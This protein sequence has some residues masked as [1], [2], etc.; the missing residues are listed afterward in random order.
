MKTVITAF[1]FII[2]VTLASPVPCVS[3]A[4]ATY[5]ALSGGCSVG[6]A[7]F[8]NFSALSFVNSAGVPA[9]T[10]DEIEVIP[11][12]TPTDA[13]LTFVYLSATGA[14]TPVTLSSSGQLFSF[15][16]NFDITVSPSSLS[17]IQMAS[18]FSNT[19]PGSV[20]TTKTA[21]LIG[22]PTFAP[23]TVS[24]GGVSNAMGTYNGAII[25]VSG[26]GTF[27]ITDTTSLQAQSGSVTQAGFENFFDLTPASNAAT[28][29]LGTLVLLGAGLIFLSLTGRATRKRR[30]KPVPPPSGIQIARLIPN[31]QVVS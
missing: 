13:T 29:E 23:S 21:Q 20:S 9:L 16:L 30:V 17:G 26:V 4:Y 18:T 15:G 5:Q 28:P 14:P 6:D 11:G 2:P 27:L 3:G 19:S 12:G 8:T 22:G 7:V 1:A 31:R 24:D 10:A 25:P